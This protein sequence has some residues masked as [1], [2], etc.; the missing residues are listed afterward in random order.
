ARASG[1]HFRFHAAPTRIAPSAA[2]LHLWLAATRVE[3][4]RVHLVGGGAGSEQVMEG[5]LVLK[6][7]GQEAHRELLASL[8]GVELV[9]SR[10]V[11]DER[12]QT[13]NPRYFAGGDC[14]SGGQEVVNAVAEGKRAAAHIA[15]YLA[16]LDGKERG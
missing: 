8:P 15:D 1:C 7:N 12:M 9:K 6:A 10:P 11:V 13:R 16:S 14:L 3:G 2:G 4:G 5:D